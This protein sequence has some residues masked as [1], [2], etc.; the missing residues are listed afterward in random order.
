MPRA[1]DAVVETAPEGISFDGLEV[2]FDGEYAF[3]TPRAS[4]SGLSEGQLRELAEGSPF[5]S[6]WFFWHATAPQADDRWA[7]LRW[8]EDAAETPVR[9]RYDRL[10]TGIATEWGQLR[11]T[12][13]LAEGG[14]RRYR[15]RHAADE[16]ADAAELERYDDPLDARELAKFADDGRY[17]PLKTAPTLAT[18]WEYPDLGP[19]ELVDAVEFF[20]P[21]TVANWH[22]ERTGELDVSH[23]QGTMA[24]QTGM[25][26]VVETWDRGEGHEHAEWVAESCC[27]DSVCLK[28]REWGYDDGTELE[29]PGGDG[30][31]PCREPC[32][33]VVS[34]ARTFT[35]LDAE[36]PRSYEFEL[37]PSEK[38]Q[39]EALVDAVAD[40]EVSGVRDA[41]FDEGANR[42][43][44][45]F[46]RARRFDD[47]GQ[48]CGRP[49]D[50]E[51]P[52]D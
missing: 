38:A 37:T 24:R 17:R 7:Y 5:V 48:L 32:S 8:L 33:L 21:A 28:R 41:D 40:G 4:F 12:A 20:Y 22:R 19:A 3:R 47:E 2:E 29:T 30:A 49:T 6:N 44:A 51:K 34:A 43:R 18:G 42:Y 52:N 23:W 10:G 9:E 26:G 35:K 27:R 16:G 50:A 11:V 25:Y 39:L 13:T 14:R 46:L 31:F 36:E 15:L 45:R 1:A